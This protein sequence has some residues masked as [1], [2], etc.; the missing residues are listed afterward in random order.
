MS[1]ASFFAISRDSVK[2]EAEVPA[3]AAAAV[4]ALYLSNSHLFS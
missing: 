2:F 4:V 3:A 1:P